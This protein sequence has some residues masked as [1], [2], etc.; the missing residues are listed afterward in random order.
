MTKFFFI[1]GLWIGIVHGAVVGSQNLTLSG[2]VPITIDISVTA[3]S[4]ATNLDLHSSQSSLL[5]GTIYESSNSSSGYLVKAKSL[6]G[7]KL[8]NGASFVSYSF[9]YDGFTSNFSGPNTDEIVKTQGTP[10]LYS[11]VLSEFRIS[12]SGTPAGSMMAGN[13]SDTITFTLENL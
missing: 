7:G 1:L 4:V 12:Y 13:Y 5:V 8:M 2:A 6:N 11:S 9:S 10:G 3:Q